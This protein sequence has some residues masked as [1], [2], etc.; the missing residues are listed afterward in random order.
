MGFNVSTLKGE[1]DS[2]SSEIIYK[3]KLICVLSVVF[4]HSSVSH[5][6]PSEHVAVIDGIRCV[7]G[8]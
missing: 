7:M 3:V 8:D 5:L 2:T 6:I 1:V 4:M